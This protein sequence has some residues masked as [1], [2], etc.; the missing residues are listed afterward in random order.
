MARLP[1]EIKSDHVHIDREF[2]L[3]EGTISNVYL[4][5]PRSHSLVLKGQAITEWI[6]SK[7]HLTC[8]HMLTALISA[9]R[10]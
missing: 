3:G 7:T 8:T 9:Q 10:Q 6:G 2:L 5:E 4:G 1:W